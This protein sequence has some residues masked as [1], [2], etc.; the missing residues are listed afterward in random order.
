MLLLKFFQ[1]QKLANEI[2]Q[3]FQVKLKKFRSKLQI[4]LSESWGKK[5]IRSK[6]MRLILMM[7]MIQ[8]SKVSWLTLSKLI[9]QTKCQREIQSTRSTKRTSIECLNTIKKDSIKSLTSFIMKSFV[10]SM[11][12]SQT[13]SISSQRTSAN[14]L[15]FLPSSSTSFASWTP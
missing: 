13:S 10:K 3:M 5:Q 6:E 12:E 8:S 11:T 7:T 9:F 14:C 4:K 15:T 1:N 2:R